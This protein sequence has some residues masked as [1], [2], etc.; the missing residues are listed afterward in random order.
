MRTYRNPRWALITQTC[1]MSLMALIGLSIAIHP[2]NAREPGTAPGY[3]AVGAVIVAA[4]IFLIVGQLTNRLLVTE[5][6]LSWRNMMRT[7]NVAW[8]DVEDVRMVSAAS[9]GP[10]YSPAIRV[11]GKLIRISSVIGSRRYVERVASDIRSSWT[12]ALEGKP[13]NG[14]S[15]FVAAPPAEAGDDATLSG[16]EVSEGVASLPAPAGIGDR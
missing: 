14:V 2:G 6:G 15:Q 1:L 4:C 10:W 16:V 9:A 3:I 12:G 7:R 5:P 11:N 13:I 8:A